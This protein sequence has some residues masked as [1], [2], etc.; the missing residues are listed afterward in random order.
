MAMDVTGAIVLPSLSVNTKFT[1]S[2][3]LLQTLQNHGLFAGLPTKDPHSH[4][5][6]VAFVCKSVMGI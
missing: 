3:G 2:S 1:V 5:Q 4:L 6:N